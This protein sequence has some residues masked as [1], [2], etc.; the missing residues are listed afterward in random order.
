MNY[1]IKLN[2]FENQSAHV[3]EHCGG[4]VGAAGI[5]GVESSC[6][7]LGVPVS[8]GGHAGGEEALRGAQDLV[9]RARLTQVP[10]VRV[11]RAHQRP[12][13]LGPVRVHDP[14]AALAVEALPERLRAATSSRVRE[15]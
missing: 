6:P 13:A 1:T 12:P 11:V 4:V 14:H 7:G 3:Y 9:C 5:G 2:Y 8:D 10:A 15:Y